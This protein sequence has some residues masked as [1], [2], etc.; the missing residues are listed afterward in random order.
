MTAHPAPAPAWTVIWFPFFFSAAF[1]VMGLLSF[2][3]PTPH[4]I[5]V[6]VVAPASTVQDLD[7]SLDESD[8]GGFALTTAPT[9]A[10]AIRLL[11]DN[12]VAAAYVIS[13]SGRG[14]LIVS[15]AASS[16][17]AD[18]LGRVADMVMSPAA[19]VASHTVT[20]LIP[21]SEGD[22]T[23]VGLFFFALPQL[24]VGLI[25]SIVLLQFPAWTWNR[26][27]ALIAAT[28]AFASVFSFVLAAS[29]DVIPVA[30]W[31]M[32]AGFAL[33]QA[34]GWLTTAAAV[35]AKRFFMPISMTFVLILGIPTA[36]ATVN[37][38]MLPSFAQALNSFLP[39]AQFVDAARSIGYFHG[40]GAVKPSVLLVAWALLGAVSFIAAHVSRARSAARAASSA[41]RSVWVS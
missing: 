7:E 31:L 22:S 34:I 14:E 2:A 41:S 15:S 26:K 27:A 10:A 24:L 18:Y 39:F 33:T 21:K 25:T 23:G 29:L 1:S 13:S 37:G 36:G 8:S 4:D 12:A 35:V 17:R 32:V 20:D 40:A 28:G 16:T 9:R 11:E 6:A 3:A 19:G 38:D 30:P 5:S